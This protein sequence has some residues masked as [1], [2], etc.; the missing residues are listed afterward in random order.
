[1]RA[2]ARHGV[3]IVFAPEGIGPRTLRLQRVHPVD[4]RGGDAVSNGLPHG[5]QGAADGG[6]QQVVLGA[7]VEENL[8]FCSG[9]QGLRQHHEG[10]RSGGEGHV[11][12]PF[13]R[14]V[15]LLNES[16][17]VVHR[18][19]LC[20]T[21]V[22]DAGRT[23]LLQGDAPDGARTHVVATDEAHGGQSMA[24]RQRDCLVVVTRQ[25]VGRGDQQVL[26]LAGFGR[27]DTAQGQRSRGVR[28]REG[29]GIVPAGCIGEEAQAAGAAG[30]VVGVGGS[31]DFAGRGDCHVVHVVGRAVVA[32]VAG[33][34]VCRHTEGVVEVVRTDRQGTDRRR[35]VLSV[36]QG[37]GRNGVGIEFATLMPMTST[38]MFSAGHLALT[39]TCDKAWRKFMG[40]PVS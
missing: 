4:G 28:T 3:F 38:F 32:P 20:R 5:P 39:T 26:L 30:P 22:I 25:A 18:R 24:E 6:C 27:D 1:M 37:S 12:C 33:V 23:D 7:V 35:G 16:R 31:P 2:V 10:L 9:R 8:D 13:R 17:G 29:V 19:P 40:T 21:E 36:G 15:K 11:G 34:G 14:C